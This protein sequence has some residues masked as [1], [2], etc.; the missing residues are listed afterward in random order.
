MATDYFTMM[1]DVVG[2]YGEGLDLKRARDKS[3]AEQARRDEEWAFRKAEMQDTQNVRNATNEAAGRLGALHKGVYDG[4][5]SDFSATTPAADAGPVRPEQMAPVTG[6]RPQ[7]G[8]TTLAPPAAPPRRD[9]TRGELLDARTGLALASRDFRT[10]DGLESERRNIK[11]DDD[12]SKHLKAFNSGAAPIDDVV[13]YINGTSKTITA[14]KDGNGFM[15]LSVVTP[16]N[17][18]QFLKLNKADQAQMFAASQMMDQDPT[19][20]LAIIKGINKDLAAAVAAEN[21]VTTKVAESDTDAAYKGGMLGESKARTGLAQQRAS[22]DRM[23]SA[24][25]FTGEDG[26]T[27]AAIPQMGKG[28]LTFQTVQVNPEG[29]KMAKAGAGGKPAPEMAKLP[30]DGTK[31]RDR[32]G[33]VFTYQGGEP[34]A[35][36][37]VPPTER[38]KALVRM[39]LPPVA[40]AMVTWAPGGRYVTVGGDDNVMYDVQSDGALIKQVLEERLN[41]N[42]SAQEGERKAGVQSR[43]FSEDPSAFVPRRTEPMDGNTASAINARRLAAE[44]RAMGLP[45]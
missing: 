29:V 32:K 38:S 10:L 25:Y 9:A 18:A 39:G 17:K 5:Q 30:D 33:N 14:A 35:Q 22:M 23:G 20:A 16:D 26:N 19:R 27:Y 15:R 13:G 1:R 7:S 2:G 12:F 24:Q 21:G 36:G 34:I 37:G 8:D 31:V 11:W 42:L 3:D 43:Q 40:E 4:S 41:A 45:R 6:L 44:R 28:G